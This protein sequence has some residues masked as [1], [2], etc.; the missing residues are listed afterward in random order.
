MKSKLIMLLA[1]LFV[2]VGVVQAADS[3]GVA[4][5]NKTTAAAVADGDTIPGG[6]AL[7]L[8]IFVA[9]DTVMGGLSLGFVFESEDAG[10]TTTWDAQVDGY[11]A[12]DAVTVVVGSRN[13]PVS[14]TI[15][16]FNITESD[17]DGNI[18]DS[19]L[20]GGASMMGDGMAVGPYDHTYSVHFT[21]G[22]ALAAGEFKQLCID[23]SFVPPAGEFLFVSEPS[24][25][26]WPPGFSGK[27]C[28]TIKGPDAADGEKPAVPFTYGLNQNY[29][30]PFNPTTKIAYSVER[31]GHVN[32][33]IFNILGQTVNTLVDE[34]QEAH[35]YEIYWHGDDDN[36]S[37]VAS[38]IYF[39]KM[40]AG[41]FVETRKMVLMR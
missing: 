22:G 16:F 23:S 14:E 7:E 36:G 27:I 17:V 26:T 21:P 13:D 34:D 30:N 10:L 28:V 25:M 37:Q 5:Y 20:I 4:L 38:G 24:G 29:P 2:S 6:D 31:K 11:G 15:D 41:D 40:T 33:S 1:V 3:V 39:Y 32:I 18:P 8:Q 35:D 9:N 19:L 12:S